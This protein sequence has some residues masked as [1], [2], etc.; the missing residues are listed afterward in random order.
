M[1][2]INK[3]KKSIEVRVGERFNYSWINIEPGETIDLPEGKGLRYGF[4][5]VKNSKE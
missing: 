3:N 5:K 1:K 2:F 4:E